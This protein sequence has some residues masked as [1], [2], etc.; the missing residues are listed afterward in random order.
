MKTE[1]DGLQPNLVLIKL[2][3]SDRFFALYAR[4]FVI[5]NAGALPTGLII[6]LTL[7]DYK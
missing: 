7:P 4:S 1:S 6:R 2:E 3:I 5:C